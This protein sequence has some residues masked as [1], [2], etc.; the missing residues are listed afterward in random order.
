MGKSAP[1]PPPAPDYAAAAQ[2]QGQANLQAGLQGSVLSN[3]NI[4]SPYGNQTVAYDD[5]M[6]NPGGTP[7]A[8]V[9]QT[10][11][12]DAQAALTAQQHTQLGEAQLAS[13]GID[14]ASQV[15]NQ[16]F[17]FQG[18]GIQ[19]SLPSAG[20]MDYGPS[21]GQYGYA[22]GNVD[23][24][25]VARAPVN[26]GTTAQQAIMARL[27]PQITQGDAAL[28]QRLANQGLRPGSEAYANALRTQQEGNNDLLSQA[29][30]QG[31]NVDLAANQQGYQQAA[32]NTALRNQAIAQNFGQGAT[33]AGL[34]NGAQNQQFN[35]GLASAQFANTAQQQSMA[36]Q[37][38]LYNQPLNQITALMSGSQIQNPQF[39]AYTGQNVQ[40]APVFQGAQ[41]Q[42]QYA[43]GLYGQQMAGYNAQM[44]ALG[45][46][47]GAAGTAAGGIWSDE[48]LKS[49]IDYIGE[50]PVGVP[51]YEYDIFGERERGVMAQDLIKVR[52]DAVHLH[53]S[54]YYMVDYD[55]I[56]GRP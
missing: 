21:A 37:L 40:A 1:Q 5:G 12:P 54:G 23:M 16:G 50:H 43:Q 20:G 32:N 30:L 36:Q 53:S 33:S 39:Q 3:P 29:A 17:Q 42:G 15:L 25:N 34:Y 35:Q 18:P 27:Q 45:A 6:G 14:K 9:T 51:A 44:G 48:R 49:S 22:N 28:Q 56:G 10:L 7:H 19:T 26:A 46:L 41:A 13:Q 11:T 31:I 8:T 55:A 52:P 2:A 47:A 24:R 4:I 38:G